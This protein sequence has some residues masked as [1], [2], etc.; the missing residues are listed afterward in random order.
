MGVQ[1][2][3]SGVFHIRQAGVLSCA[4]G[5]VSVWPNQQRLFGEIEEYRKRLILGFRVSVWRAGAD[6]QHGGSNR[7][8]GRFQSGYQCPN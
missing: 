2:S 5:D 3:G 7:L 8:G 6:D 1:E 4:P